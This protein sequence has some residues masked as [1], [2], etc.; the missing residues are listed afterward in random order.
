MPARFSRAVRFP[1]LFAA[2]LAVFGLYALWPPTAPPTVRPDRIVV[3]KHLPEL[4]LVREGQV[5]KIYT[6]SIGRN[7]V[8]PKTRAGDPGSTG[9]IPGASFTCLSISP[10]QIRR[11]RPTPEATASNREA[12]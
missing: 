4:S 1:I 5:L 6:V 7:Q 2:T 11:T 8:G 12:T 10:I 9:A 3:E